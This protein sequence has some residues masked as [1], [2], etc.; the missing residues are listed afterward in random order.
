MT[1]YTGQLIENRIFIHDIIESRDLFSE[2]YYGK[3][4]GISKPKSF[5]FDSQLVLD[6][7]EG[8]YLFVN[9]KLD[10]ISNNGKRISLKEIRNI[11][12]R[13][14]TDFEVKYIVI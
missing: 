8:Y 4:L 6:L 1:K 10:I 7:I 14:Y 5:D 2:G 9:N 11:C 3:P 13:Q 12:K